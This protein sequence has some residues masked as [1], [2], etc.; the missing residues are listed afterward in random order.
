[1]TGLPAAE[2]PAPVFFLSYARTA[3]EVP[4]TFVRQLF[5]DLEQH[6]RQLLNSL[7]GQSLGFMD[8]TMRGGELWER[9]VLRAAGTSQVFI[10]LLSNRFL[11]GSSWCATEWDVFARREIKPRATAY[12]VD[13]TAILPVLW[14]PITEPIPDL[15]EAVQRFTPQRLPNPG[16]A[17]SFEAWGI[18]G[19]QTQ[20]PEAYRSIVWSLALRIQSMFAAQYVEPSVP[21]NTEGL[22]KTFGEGRR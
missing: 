16:Y 4:D 13:E 21:A 15:V 22:R 20:D 19:L 17:E 14:A 8:M 3:G 9:R 12:S 6:L 5:A 18:Y 7:P 2:P 10:A 1:L 11:N